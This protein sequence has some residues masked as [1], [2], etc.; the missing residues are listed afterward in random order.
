[1]KLQAGRPKALAD[2]ESLLAVASP[3]DREVASAAVQRM[4]APATTKAEI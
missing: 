1:M 4:V 2:L 3:R